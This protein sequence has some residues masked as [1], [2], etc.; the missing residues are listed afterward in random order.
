MAFGLSYL[1]TSLAS[2][3]ATTH[4][5]SDQVNVGDNF[6]LGK[7]ELAGDNNVYTTSKEFFQNPNAGHQTIN[8]QYG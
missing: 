5:T 4:T 3:K 6:M 2:S 1:A 7:H 8:F